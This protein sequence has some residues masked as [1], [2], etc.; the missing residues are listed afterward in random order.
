MWRSGR[1][2]GR[3]LR[4]PIRETRLAP[5]SL[6]QQRGFAKRKKDPRIQARPPGEQEIESKF[7]LP[8][9]DKEMELTQLQNAVADGFR[10]GNYRKA[11]ED[12]RE[13]LK[14]TRDH[15]GDEHPATA[16]AFNNLGLMQKLLGD[17]DEARKAYKTA[18][19]IY[20]RVVG[21]DH[22]SYASILHNL[23]TLNQS[24]LHLDASLRATDRLTLLEQSV[25]WLSAAYRIRNDELG[26]EHPHTVA[27]RSSW[28]SATASQI[29]HHH[30]V[31]STSGPKK[32]VSL[33]SP[34]MT[35]KGWEAAHAHLRQ[36]LE[37]AIASPRG[38]KTKRAKGDLQTLS[39]ASAAQNMAVFLKAR[40]TTQTPYN[41][42]WLHEAHSL[43]KEVLVVR[44][45]LLPKGHPDLYATEYSLAELLEAFGDEEAANSLRQSIVDTYDPPEEEK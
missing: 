22:A 9:R 1:A 18:L 10:A 25:E 40:A 6:Q 43:Y 12:S 33:L 19:G 37:T 44:K 42:E 35:E 41:D 39:A 2:L 5:I 27:S 15:F 45:E 30:K 38:T 16:S 11:L 17:F 28:G 7:P 3:I 24:Q 31:T 32:Y 34:E 23:G 36:A 20:K 8:D 26:P 29:L 4:P 21:T 14:Q 13:L